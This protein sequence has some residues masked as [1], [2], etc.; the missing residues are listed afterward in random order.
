MIKHARQRWLAAPANLGV[1]QEQYADI[2]DIS[3]VILKLEFVTN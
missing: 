1:T 3:V 2:D